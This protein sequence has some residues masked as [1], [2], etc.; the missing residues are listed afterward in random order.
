M[1]RRLCALICFCIGWAMPLAAH[2]DVWTVEHD[3]L[4]RRERDAQVEVRAPV[5][6]RVL[7]PRAD[8][9]T[10][11]LAADGVY[12]ISRDGEVELHFDA[13]VLGLGIA[14]RLAA[15]PY[16]GSAWV[17]TDTP[18]LLHVARNGTLLQGTSLAAPAAALAIDLAQAAWV[19]TGSVLVRHARAP[20]LG[21]EPT[22][23]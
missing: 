15:D 9:G 18:L 11:L 13:S 21:L 19:V 2:A 17:A 1:R 22:A 10:W 12:S 14:Q 8:G 3:L 5:D 16:D 6:A 20:A 23:F 7:A 4:V